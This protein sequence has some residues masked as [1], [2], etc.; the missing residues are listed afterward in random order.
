MVNLER[1]FGK[2]FRMYVLDFVEIYPT[3][4]GNLYDITP[5]ITTYQHSLYYMWDRLTS[6]VIV[7][8]PNDLSRVTITVLR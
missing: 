3:N 6:G 7:W 8:L 2:M 4:L 5:S 1:G